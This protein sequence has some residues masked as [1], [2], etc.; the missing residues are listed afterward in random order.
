MPALS[1]YT[2]VYSTAIHILKKKG[3]Q[4]WYDE[5]SHTYWCERDGWDFRSDSPCGLLGLVAIFEEKRPKTF[6]EYWWREDEA[7][8][9]RSITRIKPNYIPVWQSDQSC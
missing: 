7:T 9:H 1:E 4:V 3:F 8:D 6:S 2:N 5:S